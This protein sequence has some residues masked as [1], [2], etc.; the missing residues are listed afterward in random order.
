MWRIVLFF[1]VLLATAVAALSWERLKE[2]PYTLVAIPIGL[3]ALAILFATFVYGRR[4]EV[5]DLKLL[6]KDLEGRVGIAPSE[7][8]IDQLNQVI[9]RSQ[10]SF[11]ELIDSFDDVAF[12]ISLDGGLEPSI[13][14]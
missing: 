6:L 12:A 7:E 8:Q 2:F 14:G 5:A 4:K 1:M 9:A 13:E 3:V 10:R 11:K